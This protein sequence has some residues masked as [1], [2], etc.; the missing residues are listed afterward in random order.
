MHKEF[1]KF[2]RESNAIEG[3]IADTLQWKDIAAFADSVRLQEATDYRMHVGA[4]HKNDME[5]M[6]YMFDRATEGKSPKEEDLL[7]MHALLS[8]DRQD[9]LYKGVYRRCDVRIGGRDG[10]VWKKV[11][12]VMAD[13]FCLWQSVGPWR[14]HV[15][16]EM[17]HP[18]ED[19]NGRTGRLL[20][21][22][23][24]LQM[25]R[26]PFRMSFLQHFYY[27]TLSHEPHR[28]PIER[29]D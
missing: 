29:I 16:Y 6:A 1:E 10:V 2:M 20:W 17:V 14:L 22:W 9:M 28:I 27:Q 19:L 11:P 8:E 3:E 12:K 24:M 13:F 26:D 18:F 21:A 7:H 23:K 15:D 5:V 25:R 4:L